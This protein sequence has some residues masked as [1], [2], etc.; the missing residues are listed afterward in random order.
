MFNK[1]REC[2]II[3]AD[4]DVEQCGGHF[5][6][7]GQVGVGQLLIHHELVTNNVI[8]HYAKLLVK[9]SRHPIPEI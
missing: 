3:K 7:G 5:T 9:L 4:V 8:M 1:L 6:S 2:E